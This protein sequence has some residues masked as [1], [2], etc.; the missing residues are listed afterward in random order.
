[1]I[2]LTLEAVEALRDETVV[3][4]VAKGSEELIRISVR[5]TQ[6]RTPFVAVRVWQRVGGDMLPSKSGFNLSPN[7]LDDLIEGL[8]TARHAIEGRPHKTSEP[9][10]RARDR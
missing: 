6:G 4:T 3:A 9:P 8:R 7:A 2:G 5:V 10:E 1:M